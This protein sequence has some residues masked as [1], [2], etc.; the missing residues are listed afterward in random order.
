[1][2][3][4]TTDYSSDCSLLILD[5]KIAAPAASFPRPPLITLC[6]WL[7]ARFLLGLFP[8]ST[9]PSFSPSIRSWGPSCRCCRYAAGCSTKVRSFW[10]RAYYCCLRIAESPFFF[11]MSVGLSDRVAL[12]SGLGNRLTSMLGW[13]LIFSGSWC[14]VL[15]EIVYICGDWIE[16]ASCH[17]DFSEPAYSNL[18]CLVDP[19]NRLGIA[20]GL[21]FKWCSDLF[22]WSCDSWP[23]DWLIKHLS[24]AENSGQP[25]DWG[26]F[27]LGM[28]SFVQCIFMACIVQS[29]LVGCMSYYF[30]M[31]WDLIILGNKK[32]VIVFI[33]WN[34]WLVFEMFLLSFCVV[35]L[36]HL[37]HLLSMYVG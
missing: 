19:D 5:P 10:S 32:Q 25:N 26:R 9:W 7:V 12:Q 28:A 15:G 20:N 1:M 8:A 29:C 14:V 37:M 30:A 31:H 2:L 27:T 22:W 4:G 6:D 13:M 17:L 18:V 23:F 35:L 3:T 33:W 34:H 36:A 21:A 11:W 16:L 24:L